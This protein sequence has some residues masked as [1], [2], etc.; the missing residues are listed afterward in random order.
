MTG[1][2]NSVLTNEWTN[3]KLKKPIAG[4]EVLCVFQRITENGNFEL[5]YDTAT[6]NGMYWIGKDKVRLN[7]NKGEVIAWYM[8][9]Y[10]SPLDEL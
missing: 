5:S 9:E 1:K 4:R 6:W 2:F 7:K 10:Y 3:A 8:F